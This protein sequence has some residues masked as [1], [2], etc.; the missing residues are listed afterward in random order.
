MINDLI[1]DGLEVNAETSDCTELKVRALIEEIGLSNLLRVIAE[2]ADTCYHSDGVDG[3][4]KGR[5]RR[6]AQEL[7][8][9]S[10]AS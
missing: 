5:L 9:L 1:I 6:F 8:T 10:E 7:I 4:F 2:S 3:K